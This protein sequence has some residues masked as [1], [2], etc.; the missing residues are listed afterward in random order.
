MKMINYKGI[1]AINMSFVPHPKYNTVHTFL[2]RYFGGGLFMPQ[3]DVIFTS[4]V[5]TELHNNAPT[6]I[7]NLIIEELIYPTI[8]QN[9]HNPD[10]EYYLGLISPIV[11]A[12]TFKVSTTL[13]TT[14][15]GACITQSNLKSMMK[16]TLA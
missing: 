2:N 11:H 10:R 13:L 9:I 3:I 12:A 8:V 14:N 16:T 6:L 1:T 4:T 15:N 5:K 7:C